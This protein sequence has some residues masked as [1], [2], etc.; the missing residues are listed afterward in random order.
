MT[1]VLKTEVLVVGSGAGGALTA[2]RLAESGLDVTLV[3]EGSDHST[4]TVEPFS[5]AEMVAKYRHGGI[6]TT[7]GMPPITYVE[8]RC[9]GGGPEINSGLYH[10]IPVDLAGHWARRWDIAEMGPELLERHAKEVETALSISPLPGPA[11]DAS[12]LIATGAGRLG[13]NVVEVPRVYR[14]DNEG[15]AEKQTMTRTFIPR[16][17]DAGARLVADWRAERLVRRGSRVLGVRGRPHGDRRMPVQTIEADHV[18]VCAGAVGTP[19]FLQHSGILRNIGSGFKLHPTI[20]LAARFPEPM[21]DHSYVPMHQVKQFA[22]D[23]TLGGSVFRPGYV[24]LA[25]GD[26]WDRNRDDAED[27]R[28]IAVYYASIRSDGGGR[29]ITVP[30]FRAPVVVYRLTPSDLSRLALG[31]V[32]LGELLFAAGATR[33]Y[34]SVEGMAPID[35][36]EDLVRLWDE[37]TASRTQLMTIHLFSSVGMGE[38]RD[39]TGADSFG[40]VWGFDNL[41]VNDASL[42]PDAPGVNPQ[43]SVM[44]IASR[45]CDEFLA[46]R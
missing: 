15:R 27:W 40:R 12:A 21:Q 28:R 5:Q 37:V 16:A 22:P 17:L 7:L 39:L 20:K 33:L 8:A 10:R 44:A 9:V 34:P 23:I 42:L 6:N 19:S 25:L 31:A 43:G 4:R 46:A 18:F 3:E 41:R 24:A 29:V 30:G 45:N 32:E 13:W 14:Y 11:P 1:N 35:R 36:R 38:R 2:A 26:A